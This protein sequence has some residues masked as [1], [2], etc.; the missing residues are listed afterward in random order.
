M[1]GSPG[2]LQAHQSRWNQNDPLIDFTIESLEPVEPI[3]E[4]EGWLIFD[5]TFTVEAGERRPDKLFQTLPLHNNNHYTYPNSIYE[6]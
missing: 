1:H 4:D 2:Y 6:C 3:G 5:V